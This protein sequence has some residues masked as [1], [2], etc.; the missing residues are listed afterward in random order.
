MLESISARLTTSP[1]PVTPAEL[2]LD[3][4]KRI[5]TR[6]LVARPVERHTLRQGSSFKHRIF[7]PVSAWLKGRGLELV[8]IRPTGVDDYLES[9]HAAENRCEDAETMLGTR[10]LDNMQSCIRSV[11]NDGIAGDM[12]EA[13]VWRGG[14]AIFMRACLKAYEATDRVVWLADS[15]AGLPFIDRSVDAFAWSAGD[16]AVSLEQVQQNFARY[17]LLDRQV[18]FVKGFFSDT[19]PGPIG[20]L[21]ILRVD[22]DLYTST[23]DVLN[24]LY[25][26]LSPGG[27]AIFDDYFNLPDCR[28]AIDEYRR[29]HNIREEVQRID[30][31]AVFWRK[32][33]SV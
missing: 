22:A 29:D 4:M 14:M 11:L 15:F 31:R 13:G 12:L 28:R 17:G 6:A 32:E 24:R 27:Y 19:L 25:S 26:K 10:Q 20:T 21:S 1:E 3:L 9:G 16:M 33:S 23:V 2:S 8:R 18:K 30:Q 7:R 5:L